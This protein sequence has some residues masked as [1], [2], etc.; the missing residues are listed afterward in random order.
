MDKVA[1]ENNY[2]LTMAAI[3]KELEANGVNANGMNVDIIPNVSNLNR[4][5]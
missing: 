1:D 4:Q 2:I 3:V 5:G